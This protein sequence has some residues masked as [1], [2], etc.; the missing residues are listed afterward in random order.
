MNN[1]IIFSTFHN[2]YY[3]LYKYIFIIFKIYVTIFNWNPIVTI[4]Y[5]YNIITS[6]RYNLKS[7][8]YQVQ[9]K[10]LK[11][12]DSIN[13]P[14]SII[15]QT[16]N[17]EYILILEYICKF[18]LIKPNLHILELNNTVIYSNL[19]PIL[20]KYKDYN[21]QYQ[22]L[23]FKKY[24][25]YEV[26][27]A[28]K[29]RIENLQTKYKFILSEYNDYITNN[30]IQNNSGKFDLIFCTLHIYQYNLIYISEE[31]NISLKV[32]L[33]LYSLLRLKKGGTLVVNIF[34]LYTKTT[35]DLVMLIEQMFGELILYRPEIEFDFKFSGNILILKNFKD[36]NKTIIKQL[37]AVF[38]KLYKIDNT[39]GL[40][41][42]VNN[43]EIRNKLNADSIVTNKNKTLNNKIKL[44]PKPSQKQLY[45]TNILSYS[46][47]NKTYQY[48]HNYT[49]TV[50]NKLKHR[51]YIIILNH[52]KKR[53]N[54][55]C[56]VYQ[57]LAS[58]LYLKK[59]DLFDKTSAIPRFYTDIKKVFYL[60]FFDNTYFN[61][62]SNNNYY[63]EY[64]VIHKFFEK[65]NI[66]DSYLEIYQNCEEFDELQTINYNLCNIKN[67]ELLELEQLCSKIQDIDINEDIFHIDTNIK[68]VKTL[69]KN[70]DSLLDATV[71]IYIKNVFKKLELIK[72][73]NHSIQRC[74]IMEIEL[75][76][77]YYRHF[78]TVFVY[79]PPIMVNS[80]ECYII[81]LNKVLTL[82]KTLN[83]TVSPYICLELLRTYSN[84][85]QYNRDFTYYKDVIPNDWFSYNEELFYKKVIFVNFLK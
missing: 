3:K 83:K 19:E 7:Y 6:S 64:K 38:N 59:F 18:N 37:F 26:T 10:Y 66:F 11:N 70:I 4:Y 25:F 9:K 74:N 65:K 15:E 27:D 17:N 73:N 63:D 85:Q 48:I 13:I 41:Y 36:I 44:I 31:Q 32:G 61:K 82:N 45:L 55:K 22:I 40:N 71:C 24:M 68:D 33:L 52:N 54:I 78:K 2:I 69:F 56:Q 84:V 47:S 30:F 35:I 42:K 12:E 1:K 28:I 75:I 46:E 81:G 49:K 53:C 79:R 23:N 62:I 34:S 60:Y 39:L 20:T 67:I 43:V 72:E 77:D 21:L 8:L 14:F 51:T 29:K 5:R 76:E 58:Y 16:D 57:L 50:F 80:N